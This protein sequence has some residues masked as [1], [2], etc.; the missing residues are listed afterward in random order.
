LEKPKETEKEATH[1]YPFPLVIQSAFALP[2]LVVFVV[3]SSFAVAFA[4]FLIM[5][6]RSSS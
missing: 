2:P 3:L 1:L 4:G 5:C 6:W